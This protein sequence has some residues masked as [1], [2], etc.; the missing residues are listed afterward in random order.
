VGETGSGY[1]AQ[2]STRP[3]TLDWHRRVDR[4]AVLGEPRRCVAAYR[5]ADRR[6]RDRAD[7]REPFPAENPRISRRWAAKRYTDIRH[8]NKLERGGH[9][10]AFE[11]PELFV[12]EVMAFFAGLRESP[13]ASS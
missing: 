7:G 13:G 1:A 12:G 3:Q 11:Q 8:W 4:T 10:G 5:R 2:Q 6:S 9:F